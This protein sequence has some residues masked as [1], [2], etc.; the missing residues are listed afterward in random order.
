MKI[1]NILII[2]I[3]IVINILFVNI[4]TVQAVGEGAGISDGIS[5]WRQFYRSWKK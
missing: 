3:I 5:R 4:N 1:K 2:M